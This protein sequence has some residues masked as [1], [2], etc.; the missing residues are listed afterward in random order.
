MTDY[1]RYIVGA[2]E[3]EGYPLGMWCQ[4]CTDDTPGYYGG[5]DER[6]TWQQSDEQVTPLCLANLIAEADEHERAHHADESLARLGH[7]IASAM[8]FKHPDPNG[9]KWRSVVMGGEPR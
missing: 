9:D 6:Q 2:T 5:Q 7:D 1:T 3:D 8:N 4:D